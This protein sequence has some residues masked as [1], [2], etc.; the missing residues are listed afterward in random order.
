MKMPAKYVDLTAEE[1]EYGGGFWNFVLAAAAVVTSC[2]ANTLATAGVISDSTALWISIGC[3][4]V[5]VACTA[6]A[7]GGVTQALT[8]GGYK[9]MANAADDV[10][11]ALYGAVKATGT[12]YK[13]TST[14]ANILI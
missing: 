9:I 3:T 14:G 1:M 11:E 10:A 8:Q 4:V 12:V 6:G 13:G 7:L 2:V 5:A